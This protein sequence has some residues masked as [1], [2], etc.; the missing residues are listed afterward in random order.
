MHYRKEFGCRTPFTRKKLVESGI[1]NPANLCYP[2]T[3][4][5]NHNGLESGIQRVELLFIYLFILFIYLYFFIYLFILF[6][7]LFIILLII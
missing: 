3:R 5:R 1:R 2:E 4:I 6:I 7:Y